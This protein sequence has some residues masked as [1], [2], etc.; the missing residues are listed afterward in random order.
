M[1]LI[2]K[3]MPF[4][5]S[6]TRLVREF[7]KTVEKVDTEYSSG[8]SPDI[9]RVNAASVFLISPLQMSKIELTSNVR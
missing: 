6:C 2:L 9:Y 7:F 8:C 1:P 5:V 4:K 3:K